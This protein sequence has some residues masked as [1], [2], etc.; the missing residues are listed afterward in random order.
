M[1]LQSFT[2]PKSRSIYMN[3]P[4]NNEMVQVQDLMR[5][6]DSLR[7]SSVGY[8][9]GAVP[10]ADAALSPLVP[11]SIE[12]S[13]SSA[14]H[15]MQ[16]LSLWPMIPKTSV[17]NT[18]HEYVVVDDH[19]FDLDP[20]IPEGGG[21]E[22][23]FATNEGRYRRESVKIKYMAE[24]RQ[25]SD[26]AT[27]VGLIGDNRNAIAE[28]TMRGTMSLMR[29]VEKQLWYGSEALNGNGFDGILKQM[30]DNA[31]SENL[32]DLAGSSITPLLL[33]DALGEAYSAP[34]FGR[35]DCIYVEPRVHADL[36]KQA[37]ASGRHDQ[38]QVLQNQGQGLTYGSQSINIM[39]PFGPV[40]VKAAPFLHFASRR[41]AANFAGH[42]ANAGNALNAGIST[43]AAGNV[44]SAF[45]A[46]DAGEYIYSFIGVGP[47]GLSPIKVLAGQAVAQDESVTIT[48]PADANY[49]MYRIYRSAKDSDS[50]HLLIGEA[51]ADGTAF[52]DHN[53]GKST[54]KSNQQKYGCSPIL[55]AQH[56]PQVMEFVRLLDF[57]RRPLAETASV[58][59]FLLMLFGSPIVK[60]P[61][62]MMLIENV[63]S[64][65]VAP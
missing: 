19:G 14:T 27:L 4:G 17:S 40:P 7:K 2:S 3:I 61:S 1:L 59:P 44:A 13:L 51:A 20:F 23:S 18:L 38:F 58:K 34:N 42:G 55:L 22:S 63:G 11:Q 52:V 25:V 62:K 6:N 5:L 33:Q 36:I 43:A 32:I 24:R 8:Q 21:S 39:A 37:V 64:N 30:R 15:T 60:V 9:T 29:K 46:S 28:E 65:Y 26:V 56:D 49:S 45:G 53:D 12:G 41:P 48:L 35:P 50:G 54:D 57:I 16:E 47:K 10:A 31:P